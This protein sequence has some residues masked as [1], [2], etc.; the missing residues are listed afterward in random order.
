M[1]S[2][3]KFK[4]F[5]C[6]IVGDDMSRIDEVYFTDAFNFLAMQY[7]DREGISYCCRTTH[8]DNAITNAV[9]IYDSDR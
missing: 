4:P 5:T 8:D 7:L 3:G 1:C 2:L 6:H 9:E